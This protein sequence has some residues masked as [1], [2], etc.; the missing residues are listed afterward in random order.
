[1]AEKTSG[2]P[3]VA[4]PVLDATAVVDYLRQHPTFLTDNAELI[5]TLSPGAQNRG[6]GVVDLQQILVTRLRE[7]I[8][9]AEESSR[10]IREVSVENL[11]NQART[12]EAA[13]ALMGARNLEHLI[14]T[15]G[16]RL[17]LIL[18]IAAVAVGVEN[19]HAETQGVTL[20]GIQVLK[21]GAADRL[22]GAGKDIR[23]VADAAPR[24][25]LFGNA[26]HMVR[27]M[28]LVRLSF[29]PTLA[30]GV[31]GL[32]SAEPRGYQPGQGTELV[33]FLART[34]EHCIRRWLTQGR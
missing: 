19:G 14:D 1:M 20:P 22:L 34:V 21:P 10:R 31:L 33:T 17:P 16:V 15:L 9:D 11:A 23:L 8:R 32:G 27:S 26:A 7:Q 18:D 6:D 2:V 30:N 12:H 28:A 3:S 4:A 25:R 29:G 13:L 5:A 24:S